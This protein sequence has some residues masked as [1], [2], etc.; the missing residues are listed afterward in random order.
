MSSNI[1]WCY[2]INYSHIWLTF[3]KPGKK[4]MGWKLCLTRN[5]LIWWRW[6]INQ[7]VME[8]MSKDD[9]RTK[10]FHRKSLWNWLGQHYLTV[11]NHRFQKIPGSKPIISGWFKANILYPYVF[12]QFCFKHNK[13]LWDL[14]KLQILFYG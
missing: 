12:P 14:P 2:A 11:K 8:W 4:R 5:H 10:I 6:N 3:L 9:E 13:L 1:D 7:N